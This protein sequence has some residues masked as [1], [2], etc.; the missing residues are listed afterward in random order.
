M[1]G[2]VPGRRRLSR[3][4]ALLVVVA[5]LAPMVPILP[6]MAV[7]QGERGVVTLTGE[8]TVSNPLLQEALSEPYILLTDL[9]NFIARDIDG[10]PPPGPQVAARL[11]GD[12]AAGAAFSLP[13]PIAPPGSVHRVGDEGTG[14]KVYSVE[15]NNNVVGEPF[16]G[17]F[18]IEQGW[19]TAYSS[20]AVEPGS[21]EVVGGRIVA[22]AEREGE[23]FPSGFGADGRLFTADDPLA[24]LPAGWTV[25]DL[26]RSPFGLGRAATI[27]VPIIEGEAGLRDLSELGYTAAFDALVE[28]LR[29]RY[30]FTDAKGIDWDALVAEFR[31]QVEAAERAGSV[32]E[33][34][35]ALVRFALRF[36]D[37]HVQVEPLVDDLRRRYGATAGVVLGRAD[38]GTVVARSVARRGPAAGV[39]I[40]PGAAIVGWD[41]R[42]V[43][44]ALAAQEIVRAASSRHVVEAQRLALLP[45]GLEGEQ[46]D[47]VFRN[48]GGEEETAALILSPDRSVLRALFDPAAGEPAELPVTVEVLPSGVGYVR[49]RS[50]FADLALLAASWEWAL[51]RLDRAGVPALIV[52]VRGNAG[53]A[54]LLATYFAGA[55]TGEPFDLAEQ[56]FAD[57]SGELVFSGTLDVEPTPTGWEKPVAVLVDGGCAS[58]CEIFAAAVAH[59]P[60][61]LIVGETPTAGV[62]ASVF[63]WELPGGIQLQAPLGRMDAGGEIFVEGRGVA[64]TVD[65][66]VTV[67]GLTS[68]EDGVLAAAEAELANATGAWSGG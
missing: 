39:G 66:P 50:F 58:A 18:E 54:G 36:G 10:G 6:A 26:D 16:F 51:E 49:V 48:P 24:P 28:E 23:A 4:A 33:F 14:V 45:A 52:D 5:L 60:A 63:P 53:G 55:F 2:R 29:L 13:L 67:E 1:Q 17:P 68:G 38:D 57:P 15:L 27:A 65:V 64:P 21:Y 35:A 61:H 40:A 42:P 12:L 9:S 20:M 59:D 11:E 31:P 3:A 44:E 32:T 34:H 37:G 47:V 25:V 41:G 30:P 56:R 22:W 46:V 43:A 7:A 62:M 19:G 8:V